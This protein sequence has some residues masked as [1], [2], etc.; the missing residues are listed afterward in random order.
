MKSSLLTRDAVWP[1]LSS[2]A[3][4]SCSPAYAAI[5]YFGQGASKLLPLPK[6]S[7]VV[8]DASDA[9]VKSG[10]T[11]PT[12]LIA[13]QKR[14]IRIY[15]VPNLHTKVYVFQDAAFIGSAN[16]SN[17]S[18][19]VLIEAMI[20]TNDRLIM[21]SARNFVRDLCLDE[22]GPER[23]GRLA[24]LYRS[25]RFM[26]GAKLVVKKHDVRPQLPRLLLAQLVNEPPPPETGRTARDGLESAKK[27]RKHGR[28]F[29]FDYFWWRGG[30]PFKVGDKVIQVTEENSRVSLVAPPADII[31]LAKWR[32]KNRRITFAYYE[33][34]KM[35]RVRLERL[36]RRIGYGAK[37][38]L[39]RDGLVR[40]KLF[41]EKLLAAFG[42]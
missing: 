38:K 27:K 23:L 18:A 41:A 9:A 30:V 32:R 14:G 28:Q 36:A 40:N 17:R 25:P 24:K 31:H 7:R 29:V 4:K 35:R 16:A 3:R 5:A 33:H 13:M 2:T 22:L 15:S 34:P 20:Q 10:Q 26:N 21:R 19:G 42:A 11:C 6:N 39:Q 37:K 8:V 12:D 1:S